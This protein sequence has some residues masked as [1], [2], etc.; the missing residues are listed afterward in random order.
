MVIDEITRRKQIEVLSILFNINPEI[1]NE[2]EAQKL[3]CEKMKELK[4]TYN[5][6][7]YSITTY[8]RDDLKKPW[9]QSRAEENEFIKIFNIEIKHAKT[10]YDLTKSEIMFLY[11]L[12]DF[13]LWEDN[14][15]VDEDGLPLNQKGLIKALEV[16]RK[17]VYR[18]IKSLEEKKC[19][20]RIWDGR[21]TYYLLNPYL[22]FKGQKINKTIP[23]LFDMLGYESYKNIK[24]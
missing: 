9:K 8:I 11:S 23:Q 10:L 19:L 4:Q 18:N 1:D 16:D 22:I 21:N 15:L 12:S 14:L 20:I 3:I 5:L 7:N 13:L 6:D 17:T 2:F 24:K